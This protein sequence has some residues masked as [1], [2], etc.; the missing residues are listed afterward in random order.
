MSMAT[1]RRKPVVWLLLATAMAL[2][3][4]A[5]VLSA[6][7]EDRR[8]QIAAATG[9]ALDS[10]RVQVAAEP[11]GPNLTVQ[12]LLKAT[13]STKRLKQTLARA[14]Q[15]GGPRFLDAQ[16]C[17][18]QLEIGGP[19]V[20]RALVEI[21]TLDKIESPVPPEVLAG[22]LRDWNNRTFSAI[23]TSTGAA[24]VESALCD[25]AHKAA[26]AAARND[27]ITQV[28]QSIRP[29]PLVNGK[30]VAD[31]LAL[32][33][34][35]TDVAKFLNDRPVTQVE[36]RDNGQARVTLAVGGD[37]LFDTF[38]S[39]VVKHPESAQAMDAA[40]WGR[41]H[42]EF[43]ARVGPVIGRGAGKAAPAEAAATQPLAIALPPS[44]PDWADRQMDAEGAVP[45]NG[46]TSKLKA[47]RAA[48]ADAG[49][50]LRVKVTALPLSPQ[51]TLGDA[52]RQNKP[53]AEAIDRSLIHARTTKVDY[54]PTGGARV[55][56]V[57]DLN[58]VWQE[59]QSP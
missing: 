29:I 50:K 39:A 45:A 57:L 5:R 6:P 3:L 14:Q 31:A 59:L 36:F 30:T 53:I 27:A 18:V 9:R 54:P 32:P 43:V 34:V 51:L 28:L 48:E 4:P 56:V 37:E 11:I 25:G 7:P 33:A 12:D 55:T 16:T 58:D 20:A 21:A 35:S 15:I 49:A 52:A 13:N 10:L 17:Q 22:R 26:V 1:I 23:A 46:F 40:A 44:P 2:V 42:D 41:V 47:A 38:R 19:V 8:A 24:A